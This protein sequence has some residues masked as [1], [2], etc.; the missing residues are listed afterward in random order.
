MRA[1]KQQHRSRPPRQPQARVPKPLRSAL[2]TVLVLA[3]AAGAGVAAVRFGNAGIMGRQ[4]D[5]LLRQVLHDAGL[6]VRS[7]TVA[8]RVQTEPRELLSALNISRNDSILHIDLNAVHGRLA[9]LPWVQEVQVSRNLPNAVHVELIERHPVAIWQRNGKMM[10][11]DQSGMEITEKDVAE[12]PDLPLIVGK[13]A[14]KAASELIALLASE[15]QLQQR[16]AAAVRVGERRW[17]LRLKDGID[18]RLPERDAQKAW[19]KLARYEESNGL[20]GRDVEFVDLRLANRVV[21]RL[22]Q[23]AVRKAAEP[24]REACLSAHIVVWSTA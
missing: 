21:V 16:V 11:V 15:P 13:G 23:G 6:S 17:N 24:G 7:I 18:V 22:T 9:A 2:L 4:G 3:L 12:Y 20:L 1:V 5:A 14:P 19:R 8:G 10:L